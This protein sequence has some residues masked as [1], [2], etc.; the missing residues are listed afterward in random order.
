MKSGT[1][2]IVLK[3][4]LCTGTGYSYAGVIDSDAASDQY[5]LPFIPARRLKGCLRES[6][7]MI[8]PV[9]DHP[10]TNQLF[11]RRGA[12]RTG[13]LIIDNALLPSWHDLQAGLSQLREKDNEKYSADRIFQ[14]FTSIRAQTKIDENGIAADNSLRFTRVVNH[15]LPDGKEAKFCAEVSFPDEYEEDLEK[16]VK[17]TRHIGMDR[18]RGLGNVRCMLT[19][20]KSIPD[21][22]LGNLSSD[23]QPV[24]I[25]YM[26]TAEEPL[27]ISRDAGSQS[28]TYIPGRMILGSLASRYLSIPGC[29]AEDTVFRD[30]FLNGKTQ[31]LNVYPEI[32]GKRSIPVP[33]FIQ[34]MKKSK[35]LINAE[36]L[37]E[38]K[39]AE[40]AYN[41]KD[42][43]QPRKLTGKYAVQLGD[44]SF[45]IH[46]TDMR[47]IYHH[48]HGSS[49]M[50]ALLYYQQVIAEG[51]SFRGCI[52]VPG[53][54]ADLVRNLLSAVPL[55]LGK[56]KTA[57]YGK[58]VV[59]DVNCKDQNLSAKTFAKGDVLLV[60]L[61][62][63]AEFNTVNGSTVYYSDICRETAE[64]LGI[65]GKAEPAKLE[66]EEGENQP[67][68]SI[69]DC[70][71]EGGYQA[72]WNLRRKPVPV[73][74]AGSVLAYKLTTD[75]TIPAHQMIG[76]NN[77]EGYGEVF[78]FSCA[79][80]NYKLSEVN[81][82]DDEE[83]IESCNMSDLNVLKEAIDKK[84]RLINA[85]EIIQGKNWQEKLE[86]ISSSSIGRITLMLRESMDTVGRSRCSDADYDQKVLNEFKR[87][88]ESI[89]KDSVR[90][91]AKKFVDDFNKQYKKDYKG[92]IAD[93]LLEGLTYRKYLNGQKK[94]EGQE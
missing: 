65:E 42:G 25:T 36:R 87:R 61:A 79:K 71:L 69:L 56:S 24:T 80:M 55:R 14:L 11:G 88:I 41:P 83:K 48:R 12:E 4:D 16:I 85:A 81:L 18:N 86:S 31:Y 28:V 54:Y 22:S 50:E 40:D 8:S 89:K 2:E 62:S 72:V 32:S 10:N 44:N 39:N 26:L 92:C 17:A 13:N 27:M 15:F 94:G 1:I 76:S 49:E 9:L 77:L 82:S 20:V 68:C 60:S 38:Q 7:E 67:F 43:N 63:D 90:E 91:S 19:N 3:S 51:Q 35:K 45:G 75:V 30:L 34:R 73:V 29:S 84:D 6:A 74:K 78:C 37:D 52:V 47:L 59:S 21:F 58:C 66:P 46:E 70:G 5:G 53:K 57:Q 93:T 23:E 33:W 64:K